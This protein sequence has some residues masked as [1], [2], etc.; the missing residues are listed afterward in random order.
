MSAREYYLQVVAILG[1]VQMRS[2]TVDGTCRRL[3]LAH[4]PLLGKRLLSVVSVR[5]LLR[6]RHCAGGTVAGG[7]CS[8]YVVVKVET[9]PTEPNRE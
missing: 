1:L 8:I 7:E 4:R 6:L 9:D 5:S 3:V 2:E